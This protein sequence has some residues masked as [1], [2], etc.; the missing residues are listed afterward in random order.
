VNTLEKVTAFITRQAGEAK[1]LLVFQHP[2][3]GV[4]VPAGTV[5][6]GEDIEQAVL[7][8]TFEETGLEG[9][10]LICKLDTQLL[11]PSGNERALLQ[12]TA[13]FTEPSVDS[14]HIDFSPGR[15]W[16]VKVVNVAGEWSQVVYEEYDLNASP[17]T[18]LM[19]FSGW[20]PSRL[21]ASRVVRHFFHLTSIVST[22]DAWEQEAEG[23]HLF[24]LYWVP[25]A[26]RPKLIEGQDAWLDRVYDALLCSTGIGC[27]STRA[28]K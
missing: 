19:R 15:G 6:A 5:E 12:A 20:V 1:E 3:A 27:Q 13:L 8:E 23:R 22:P 26:P 14:P 21:L 24:R 2:S 18:P 17:P 16:W 11:D 10:R 28:S 9:V 25:L 4:Q 7:R